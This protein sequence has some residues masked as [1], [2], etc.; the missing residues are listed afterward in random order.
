MTRRKER[1]TGSVCPCLGGKYKGVCV[2][3]GIMRSKSTEC[4]T[5]EEMQGKR[6]HS[7]KASSRLAREGRLR[8]KTCALA[9]D[10]TSRH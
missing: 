7:N 8:W 5:R 10:K 6:V 2:S 1:M 3:T 4:Y 9:D